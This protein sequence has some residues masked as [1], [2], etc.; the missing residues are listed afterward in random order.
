[1]C[2]GLATLVGLHRQGTYL[3]MFLLLSFET[4]YSFISLYI[5]TLMSFAFSKSFIK[6]QPSQI[7]MAKNLSI[8]FKDITTK[9]MPQFTSLFSTLQKYN[10]CLLGLLFGGM[11]LSKSSYFIEN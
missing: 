1:M 3:F 2:T 5:V 6:K 7:F 10:I 8:I 11:K 4:K 9:S